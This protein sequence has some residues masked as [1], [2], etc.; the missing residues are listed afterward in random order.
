[1]GT[2]LRPGAGIAVPRGDSLPTPLRENEHD[3][4]IG[5]FWAL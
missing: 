2:T 4:E 3:G 5:H 1:M